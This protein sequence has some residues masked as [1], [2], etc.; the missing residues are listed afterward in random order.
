MSEDSSA[1]L[2]RNTAIAILDELAQYKG[3]GDVL[4]EIMEDDE[5]REEMIGAVAEIIAT[6]A[7]RAPAR[8]KTMSD[9]SLGQITGG[10]V[11]AAV[12]MMIYLLPP[13]VLLGI[14]SVIAV[15]VMV[16]FILWVFAFM[17]EW[18]CR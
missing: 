5:V 6:D 3:L 10:V 11:T 7:D 9:F 8:E 1:L 13:S 4:D 18:L 14:A 16:F 12:M 17:Y 2:W 15:A